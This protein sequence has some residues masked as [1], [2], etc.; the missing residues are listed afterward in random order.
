MEIEELERKYLGIPQ[1]IK[2]LR[3]WIC[4]RIEDR[5]GRQTKVPYSAIN[6]A[7]A[8]SNDPTTWSTFRIAVSGCVKFRFDG[9]GFMLG[10]NPETGVR[11]FGIDLDNHADENG[12]KPMTSEEFSEFCSEFIEGLDSYTEYSH[13]GEGVHIICKGSLP[14]GA[15]RKNGVAVEMYDKGRFFTMS[16]RVIRNVPIN[17]RTE[18][19]KPIWEKWLKPAEYAEVSNGGEGGFTFGEGVIQKRTDITP[20]NMSDMDLMEKIRSSRY[21][22]EFSALYNG[23]MSMYSNDHSAADLAF[24]KILAFWT[25]CDSVQ[26]DRIFRGSALMRKKWDEHRGQD[27]YGSMTIS[28]AISQQRDTYKPKREY[29]TSY[30]QEKPALSISDSAKEGSSA[31]ESPTEM[32]ELDERG[33]PKISI[34]Q[35]FKK[36]TLDDTGNAE[37]F[38]DYFGDMFRFNVD[39]NVFM[40]WDGK[41]WIRDVKGYHRKYANKL[42]DVLKSEAR[43]TSEQIDEA[44]KKGEDG[45]DEAKDLKGILKAQLD[46]I[47]R[48]SNKSGKDAMLAELHNLHD[49]PVTNA[50]LDTYPNL[51]NTASGVI[52]LNTGEAKPFDRKYMLSK[53]TNCKVD[54]G[55]PTTF[56]KFIRDVLK[57]PTEQETEE[58]VETVQMAL[59]ESLT[60]R[61][62]KEHLYIL[63]G[64]GSN[65]KSTFIETVNSIFGDYGTT[66]NSDMLIQKPNSSSQSNEF[67]LSALLGARMVSTSETAEGKRLDEVMIKQMLS[68]ERI[69]A[70]FKYGQPFSFK[71]AF[72]PWMSTNNK[73]VIR[74][75]DF[76]TWRRIFFIP[77]LNT[78][79]DANKDVD[80]PAKLAAEA[81]KILG[82]MIKGA[83]RLH[84]EFS[85][86]LPKPK[87]LE[88][89]LADYKKELDVIVTF[90]NDRCIP[91]P[92]MKVEA[93][94]LYQAYKEWAKNNGEYCFSESRFKQEMPKKGYK[95][96]KDRNKGWMYLDIKMATDKKGIIFGD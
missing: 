82:W 67:S 44:M 43:A 59:G 74:A 42:I 28:K 29:A 24:C 63:Y 25:G 27:T 69:N 4:Y 9:L 47:K 18:R 16:G 95:L 48:V 70:Q 40:F 72:S 54:F 64:T 31:I 20:T 3:R 10:E 91:F 26:M 78:F 15:R 79:T 52:D 62:N 11:Y 22:S 12:N 94:V 81:P 36:Y 92:G 56:M 58:L 17:D 53:N 49:L 14:E 46:N 84:N 85:D 77:F 75:T 38:Y 2:Q 23:D 65:G 32:L 21:G 13:S 68:G 55:E 80:M 66:M 51:L 45:F 76:G 57:R 96:E 73:P 93:S 6:G 8:K 7:H 88:E 39:N 33:D 19:I 83:V 34:K 87:C 37:R 5:D 50:E 86:K 35:I 61:T 30:I 90:L 60:G 41:T 89:A 71:P 1:E